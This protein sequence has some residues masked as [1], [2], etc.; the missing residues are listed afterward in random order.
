MSTVTINNKK[1]PVPELTFRHLPMMEKSGLSIVDMM[2]KKYIFTAVE[3]FTAIVVGCETDYADHLLE[4]H[5]LGGGDVTEIYDAFI[6]AMY[7]SSFF[8]KMLEDEKD[9]KT[10]ANK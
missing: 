4:Q 1:Y 3:V 6:T 8:S 7:E 5:I 2:S 10:P 9:Q